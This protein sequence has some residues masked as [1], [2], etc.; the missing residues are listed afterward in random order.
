VN[1]LLWHVHGSWTTAF[2]S[3]RHTYVLPVVPDR[4]PEG[5]GRARTWRWPDRA[6]E[7]AYDRGPSTPIDVVI[8]QRPDDIDLARRFLGDRE[9]GVDVP[10]VWL[11]HN[12]PQGRINEMRHPAADRRDL[13]LVHVTPTNALFWDSACTRTRVIEH[14]ILDPG[15]RYS[16]EVAR[17]AVV[18]NEPLRRGRVVGTDLLAPLSRAAPLDVYGMGVRALGE[19]PWFEPGRIGLYEDLPQRRLHSVMA[20]RRFYLHPFRWTSLGLSLVEAMHL[21][22]PVVALATT[23]APDVVPPDAGIVSNR[24]EVLRAGM[25]DLVAEPELARQMGKAARAAALER[26]GIHRFLDEWD[27]LLEEVTA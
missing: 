17:G 9:P 11:E 3:G 22:M 6:V 26:H 24:V 27:R 13:T 19:Q 1:V 23:E 5:R 20:T 7:V 16:G 10:L 25:R 14:G 4:G 12:A 8:A 21:G 15:L 2:V 18:V